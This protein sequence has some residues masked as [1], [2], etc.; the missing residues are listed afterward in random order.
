MTS[1]F[2]VEPDDDCIPS[3][4]RAVGPRSSDDDALYFV[5]YILSWI[6]PFSVKQVSLAGVR[7]VIHDRL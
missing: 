4:L 7:D 6:T 2:E 5:S 1:M 3:V